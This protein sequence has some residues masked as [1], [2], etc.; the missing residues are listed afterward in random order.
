MI[1]LLLIC[2]TVAAGLIA[3]DRISAKARDEAWR[4]WLE[5]GRRGLAP[6][7][8]DRFGNNQPRNFRRYERI[9]D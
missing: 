8:M 5:R 3:S 9:P 4:S 1:G 6:D 2:I 7:G